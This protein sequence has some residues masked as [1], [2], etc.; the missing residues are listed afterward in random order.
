[1]AET[2]KAHAGYCA[3]RF[4]ANLFLNPRVIETCAEYWLQNHFELTLQRGSPEPQGASAVDMA[5]HLITC[6]YQG[7]DDIVLVGQG[8]LAVSNDSPEPRHIHYLNFISPAGRD[9]SLA[10][11]VRAFLNR[12][13]EKLLVSLSTLYVQNEEVWRSGTHAATLGEHLFVYFRAG[14][15]MT[16]WRRL[17]S[18]LAF[19]LEIACR[20]LI[21]LRRLASPAW[22]SSESGGMSF[23]R[24]LLTALTR[25]RH[26]GLFAEDESVIITRLQ[27]DLATTLQSGSDERMSF[28]CRRLLQARREIRQVLARKYEDMAGAL[29]QRFCLDDIQTLP[30]ETKES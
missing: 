20:L 27:A 12:R 7:V 15:D 18:P 1:M 17:Y 22:F 16:E 26:E 23:L 5:C 25:T 13:T 4:V 3:Y 11:P 24:A 8:S 9:F 28:A 14:P 2:A 10:L 21:G 19:G 30:W 29:N 6:V